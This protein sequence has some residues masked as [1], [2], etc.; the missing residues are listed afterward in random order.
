MPKDSVTTDLRQGP[1][2]QQRQEDVQPRNQ[3]SAQQPLPNREIEAV[4]LAAKQRPEM[5]QT[6][7]EQARRQADMNRTNH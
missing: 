7:F 5:R 3:K 4:A 6:G 2:V 1:M